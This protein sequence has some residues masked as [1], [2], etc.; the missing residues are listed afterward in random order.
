M[1]NVLLTLA[2]SALVLGACASTRGASLEAS[3][4][5]ATTPVAKGRVL[6]EASC[7]RCHALY[8]PRSY[9]QGEWRYFVRKY[10]KRA[11][12]DKARQALV[13]RYLEQNCDR[14]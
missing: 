7:A 9:T 14:E 13:F 4:A 11:R 6:Y 12:L 8:M 5:S 2:V 10:G 3:L 1:G